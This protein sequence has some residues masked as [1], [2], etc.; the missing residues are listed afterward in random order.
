MVE[1]STWLRS[2]CLNHHV[3]ANVIM[4]VSHECR[5]HEWSRTCR[6]P[7]QIG[8]YLRVADRHRR[9]T[10]GIVCGRGSTVASYTYR[11]VSVFSRL[12]I[13]RTVDTEISPEMHRSEF[14]AAGVDTTQKS[15][16]RQTTSEHQ[17][18]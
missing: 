9:K 6:V 8:H 11:T 14:E 4:P 5:I 2:V 12:M 10:V 13:R 1:S 3:L 18:C 16:P 17:L 7:L 15:R